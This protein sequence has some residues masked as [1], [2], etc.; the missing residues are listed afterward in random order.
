[1]GGIKDVLE[2]GCKNPFPYMTCANVTKR[3][4]KLMA[5]IFLLFTVGTLINYQPSASSQL[6]ENSPLLGSPGTTEECKEEETWWRRLFPDNT[7]FR[8]H[9]ASRFLRH[10]PFLVEIL[11]WNLVY[12]TYQLSRA[13][14]AVKIRDNIGVFDKSRAH[15]LSLLALE[16]KYHIAI[17]Q[18]LQAWVLREIPALM[19]IC[20]V[21]Y[22][23]HIVVS[24]AFVIYTFTYLPRLRFQHIRRSMAVCN[25]IAFI[26]LSAYRVMPPR[27]LPS[28]YGFV[29]VLHPENGRSGSSWTNNRFQLTIAAMP[30]LHFGISA[31]IAYSLL[32]WSPHMWLRIAAPFWPMAMLFTILATANH[33]LL[34]ACVGGL[35]LIVAFTVSDALLVLRPIEEWV[36]WIA[37]MEK[38]TT[39][40]E[41][42][43]AVK[44]W[45]SVWSESWS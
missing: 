43:P 18:G 29:D 21:I 24:V 15:A 4:T 25:I 3:L 27:M 11:Y 40:N 20:A 42:P 33:F 26:I 28:R 38:P 19:R 7:R 23:S 1:M 34:D 17:E 13:L 16:K 10:F 45:A 6:D 5:G 8:G 41:D 9:K 14:S 44:K 2:P 36:F 12:W 39:A 35:V 37:R 32:R 30:S 31:L 22:Y